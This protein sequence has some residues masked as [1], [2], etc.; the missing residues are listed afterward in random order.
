M[1]PSHI[2]R[3]CLTG[4]T[5]ALGSL[6]VLSAVLAWSLQAG[7]FRGPLL[8][9]LGRSMDRDIHVNGPLRITLFSHSPTITAEHVVIG[10]PSWVPPGQTADIEKLIV[11]FEWPGPRRSPGITRLDLLN[12]TF[13]LV[14]DADGHANWQ[15]ND[16]DAHDRKQAPIIKSFSMPNARVLLDDQR[17]HLRFDGTASAHEVPSPMGAG[18][19][20]I[21][22]AGILN[23]RR[24]TFNVTGDAL[25]LTSRT[26]PYHFSFIAQSSGSKLTGHGSLPSPFDFRVVDTTFEA[27]GEDLRDLRFLTGV[28]L[29]NTGHYQ[30][31]GQFA[32][33]GYQSTVSSLSVT[34]G[35]SD[36]QGGVTID[37][38]GG[39]PKLDAALS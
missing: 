29:V 39:R 7:H 31:S 17:R 9:F 38:S 36:V 25:A 27:S 4:L 22:G 20:E 5:F 24:A 15:W 18:A 3:R 37:S 33:R 1:N 10:N 8:R 34:F 16:P 6:L 32:L 23:G 2:A 28:T 13:H 14:Q 19:L 21:T 30:L 26:H 11:V 35:S 12:P